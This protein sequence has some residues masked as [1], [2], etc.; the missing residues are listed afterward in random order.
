[1]STYFLF[2]RVFNP[3]INVWNVKMLT[4]QTLRVL[5]RKLFVAEGKF[6]LWA[7][8]SGPGNC[9]W[10]V[11]CARWRTQFDGKS[12]LLH[13]PL[14]HKK[15]LHGGEKYHQILLRTAGL[16]WD[17]CDAAD[18]FGCQVW[19]VRAKSVKV[20]WIFKVV[21]RSLSTFLYCQKIFSRFLLKS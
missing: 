5:T 10:R 19:P 15:T 6:G 7:G 12:D 9:P 11:L 8:G 18:N 16:R 4:L 2:F 13:L 21:E 17:F 3:N 20:V 1:M 14:P